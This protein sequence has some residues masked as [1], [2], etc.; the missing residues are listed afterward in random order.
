MSIGLPILGNLAGVWMS[1]GEVR[2][3]VRSRL[4]VGR[5]HAER[6]RTLTPERLAEIKPG[7]STYDDVARLGG[8]PAEAHRPGAPAQRRP[9]LS[10]PPPRPPAPPLTPPSPPTLPPRPLHP[11]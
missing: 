10:P 3:F 8:P 2:G 4:R 1:S 11:H 7:Q 9:P 5:E 6:E